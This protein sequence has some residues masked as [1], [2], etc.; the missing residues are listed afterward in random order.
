LGNGARGMIIIFQ[1]IG[2]VAVI[3]ALITFL[4]MKAVEWW[5][6]RK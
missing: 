3:T 5:E 2:V 4:G 1:L 6:C